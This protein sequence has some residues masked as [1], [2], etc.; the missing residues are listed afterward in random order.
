MRSTPAQLLVTLVATLVAA[1]L[2]VYPGPPPGVDPLRAADEGDLP[3][4]RRAVRWHLGGVRGS[5]GKTP[6]HLAVRR[7]DVAAARLLIS[8]GADIEAEF[9]C[10]G[11]PLRSAAS[12]AS[13]EAARVLLDA[14]AEVNATAGLPKSPPLCAAVWS[15]N[16]EM[17]VLLLARGADVTGRDR[18]G[19][20]TIWLSS[21]R[22]TPEIVQLLR[23]AGAPE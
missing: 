9:Y 5:Y 20:V 13:V 17:V 11:T 23:D 18:D 7:N 10:E 19:R 6:L 3:Q 8:G 21:L 16:R 14:G 22:T 15:G 12:H 4:L 1:G 2:F